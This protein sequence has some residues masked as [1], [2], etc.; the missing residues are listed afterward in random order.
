MSVSVPADLLTLRRR[1]WL[2]RLLSLVLALALAVLLVAVRLAMVGLGDPEVE[3]FDVPARFEA[4]ARE[5]PDSADISQTYFT[6]DT[7]SVHMHVMGRGQ[8]CP[9]HIH[10]RTH[11]ATIIVTGQAEVRQS[12]GDGDG[13]AHRMGVHGP[14]EL[15]ASPPFT[16]HAW[17]NRATDRMLG[18][19]VF[20]WP[21][22]D[23][24]LYVEGEDARMTKGTAPFVH[25]PAAALASFRE[26]VREQKL[27]ALDGRMSSVLLAK[28]THALVA[29]REAP[30][31]VY[32]AEGEGAIEAPDER[33]VKPG[34]LWVLRRDAKL[35]AAEGR[36]LALYVFRPGA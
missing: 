14:G 23:G 13:L 24:N 1:L 12:W 9:L 35:R 6:E 26:D 4:L 33:P 20:A 27:P 19:L 22:F 3:V 32:V 2:Y 21:P 18:N 7:A 25:V 36:P 31:V 28:G 10:R 15:I 16:G 8:T 5:N 34:Q 11:E 17:F 30:V 29:T